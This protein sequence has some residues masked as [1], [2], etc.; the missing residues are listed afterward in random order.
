MSSKSILV[1]RCDRAGQMKLVAEKYSLA[2]ISTVK[3]A[4]RFILPFRHLCFFR[5][6]DL[7]ELRNSKSRLNL[8]S[9]TTEECSYRLIAYPLYFHWL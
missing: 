6:T 9:L 4:F 3:F 5:A 7:S 8:A 1:L 2:G